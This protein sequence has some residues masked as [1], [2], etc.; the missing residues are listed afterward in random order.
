LE[1]DVDRLEFQQVSKEYELKEEGEKI[2]RQYHN[3]SLSL[4]AEPD[5]T[6]EE[7]E[8][9]SSASSEKLATLKRNGDPSFES[10]NNLVP[11]R[12]VNNIGSGPT[13]GTI[14]PAAWP[15]NDDTAMLGTI[16]TS[17]T[18][19]GIGSIEANLDLFAPDL[20]S[21]L[22]WTLHYTS[23][24]VK[25]LNPYV[26]RKQGDEEGPDTDILAQGTLLP[27]DQ[28]NEIPVM[29]YSDAISSGG[30]VGLVNG[31]LRIALQVSRHEV[32][33]LGMFAAD[34][35]KIYGKNWL[36][37]AVALWYRDVAATTY[38][39]PAPK[40]T[41][42][43]EIRWYSANGS[44]VVSSYSRVFSPSLVPEMKLRKPGSGKHEIYR[45]KLFSNAPLVIELYTAS[46]TC[47]VP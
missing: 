2:R 24:E 10:N 35:H 19:R 33:L 41:S 8:A 15:F 5:E 30:L 3:L 44:T 1:H 14:G 25:Q 4:P 21:Q 18:R 34:G 43:S 16:P 36:Q 46:K 45:R 27:P 9:S 17:D 23:R 13:S 31:W 12:E 39:P 20:S 6:D 28:D 22:P 32:F 42:P 40:T 26:D 47:S 11:W 7:D 29:Q 37:E 38:I